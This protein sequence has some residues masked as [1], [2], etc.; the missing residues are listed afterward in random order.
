M[1]GVSDDPADDFFKYSVTI[2]A[3][4][5]AVWQGDDHDVRT[6][7]PAAGLLSAVLVVG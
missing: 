2:Q 7:G 1:P 4:L 6:G 3:N 5:R